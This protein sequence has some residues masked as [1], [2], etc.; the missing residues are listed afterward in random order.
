MDTN[1]KWIVLV[2]ICLVGCQTR[3]CQ[4]VDTKRI[5]KACQ[6]VIAQKY[7]GGKEVS[8]Q[9]Q[10]VVH[11]H[12]HSAISVEVRIV[13]LTQ[14]TGSGYVWLEGYMEKFRPKQPFVWREVRRSKNLDRH[15]VITNRLEGSKEVSR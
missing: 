10:G 12:R 2:L 13:W 5:R 14:T 8:V 4:C 6:N 15:L 7:G 9:I 1:F 3:D 11:H